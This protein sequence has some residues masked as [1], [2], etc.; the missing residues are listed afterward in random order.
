MNTATTR[1]LLRTARR[2]GPHLDAQ[3]V[4]LLLLDLL[5]PGEHG[6]ALCRKLRS[7]STIP[8][9]MLSALSDETER[10]AGLELGADDYVSKPFSARELLA[11]IRSVLRR[12][13]TLPRNL[14]LDDATRIRFAG[15]ILDTTERHA[16]SPREYVVALSGAEYYLLRAFLKFPNRVLTREQLLDLTKGREMGPSDRSIDVQISRLRQRLEEDARRPTII[17]TVWSE[18]YVLAAEVRI[19]N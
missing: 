17:K 19:D 14:S 18:G 1:S 5:L 16:I 2:C 9:I 7:R 6:L 4:D 3:R 15:W 8:V 12:S 13:N 10:V 11:R